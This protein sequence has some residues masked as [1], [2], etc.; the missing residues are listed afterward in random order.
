MVDT[1]NP[2]P[3]PEALLIGTRATVAQ[4][5]HMLRATERRPSVVGCV[6]IE[7]DGGGSGPADDGL[8][9]ANNDTPGPAVLGDLQ[10]LPDVLAARPVDLVLVSLPFEMQSHTRSTARVL[11]D[12][13]VTWRIVPTIDDQLSGQAAQMNTPRATQPAVDPVRL[14]GRPTRPIDHDAIRCAVRDRVVLITGAGGSIGSELANRVASFSPSRLVLVERS[15]NAL[16]E[17]DRAIASSHPDLHRSA[18]LHDVTDGPR[19]A[20]LLQRVGPNVV[21]HAAAHK[22]V[23]MMEDHPAEAVENNLYGTRSI[24]EA[25]LDTGVDRLVMVSTNKA[26]NPRSVMGATKR[27]AEMFIQDAAERVAHRTVMCMV[28]FGNVLGSACS[29]LP[30]W[31]QQ[32][33]QGGALTVTHPQMTRYFMT[34]P[35]A[36]DLLLQSAAMASGGEVYALDMGDPIRIV[37]LAKR[38]IQLHDLTPGEDVEITFTQPRPG[39]KL[40][41]SPGYDT[42]TT[43]VTQHPAVRVCDAPPPN[44]LALRRALSRFDQLRTGGPNSHR[45]QG[46]TP[47]SIL[48]A[49]RAAVPEMQRDDEASRAAC[50]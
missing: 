14:I 2:A 30:I 19:T 20:A 32:L 49:L 13:R 41:E 33:A 5:E 18:E 21:L 48:D 6:L 26:V 46:A 50:A 7:Q 42:L 39:E 15:E 35:E 34:I 4:L 43:R 45:W 24:V 36:A 40:S 47:A 23:P 1:H 31:S 27:L 37:D 10:A 9:L 28:R 25:A 16:F 8:A 11:D 17:V 44:A 38:F 3:Q 22:H 29:V 12:A